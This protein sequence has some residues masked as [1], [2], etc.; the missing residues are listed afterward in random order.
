MSLLTWVDEYNQA[1]FAHPI[2]ESYDVF[3]IEENVNA[4]LDGWGYLEEMSA[5]TASEILEH[6]RFVYVSVETLYKQHWDPAEV[7]EQGFTGAY[8]VGIIDLEEVNAERGA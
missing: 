2:A 4:I 1:Y 6:T 5:L 8:A 7:H 3:D